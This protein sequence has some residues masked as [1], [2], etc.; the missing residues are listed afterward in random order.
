MLL[1]AKKTSLFLPRKPRNRSSF[2]ICFLFFMVSPIIFGQNTNTPVLKA[3]KQIEKKFDVKFSYNRRDLKP[4]SVTNDYLAET[5][6]ITL[7]RLADEGRLKFTQIKERYIAVQ[8]ETTPLFSVCGILIETE[9]SLPIA[10]AE[11]K[12]N[13]NT[14]RSDSGGNF[15]IV[16][17]SER[18]NLSIFV[19]GF[20]AR[21]I[22]ARELKA[23]G[24]CPFIY[25]SQTYTY[26]PEVILTNYITKGISKNISG[27]TIIQ[28]ENFDILPSLIEPD[29]LQIA[30]A[31]PGVDS[32]D[33]TAAN[34]NVRGGTSDEFLILWDDVRMY[35]SGHFFGLISAFNPNLTK[36]VTLYKNGTAARYGEG[37]SGVIAM[38]S[39]ST[40]PE[41]FQGGVGVNLTSA[42]AY[43]EIPAAE[44]FLI[45]VSG[46][47]SINTGIGNP[48]YNEFFS[49][50]FQN[51]VVTNLQNNNIEGERSTDEQ[52][53][54]FDVS[55][56]SL[57]KLT[58]N[59]QLTYHFLRI[60]NR[61]K[62][63]ER[64]ISENMGSLIDS[65]LEQQNATNAITY[66]R[67]WNSK[68]SSKILAATSTYQRNEFSNNVDEA[69]LS[70]N[71]NEV[72][73]K[74]VK[75][76]LHYKWSEQAN[77]EAGYQYTDTQIADSQRTSL[78]SN[79]QE[80]S[81]SLFSNAIFVGGAFRL[82]DGKT[83][84]T[85]GLRFTYYPSLSETFLEPRL[86]L[87]QKLN[88][89]LRVHISAETK[90]Q[91]V[92][93]RVNFR[94]NLL[95]VETKDWLLANEANNPI[96]ESQ[97][98]GIGGNFS[99]ANWALTADAYL[100]KVKG[101]N[102]ANLG[103]RNQ[104]QDVETIG[105]YDVMGFE[106]SVNRQ[107]TQWNVWVSYSAQKNTYRFE[108]LN[109][110]E[111]RNNLESPHSFTLAGSYDY[112]NFSFSLGNTL[113]SGLPYTRPNDEDPFISTP[114][115][116][117]INFNEPNSD[118]LPS[119]FRSDFSA[120]YT[121]PLDE[122]FTGKIN[123]AFLNIFNRNNAL[124]RYYVLDKNE[125]G[126]PT[127]RR[128]DQFSLGFTPNV[129]LQLLF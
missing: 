103:F 43:A 129:S 27:A 122:T 76:D 98:I 101:I 73:E 34:I 13:N 11:I 14:V 75:F 48:V 107:M 21:I 40:I 105:S 32:A 96:L 41:Q 64:I 126:A 51:T 120:S 67:N 5:L 104:F 102:S 24:S 124:G 31:L 69:I 20:L 58:A 22:T 35:L 59:D 118:R 45:T 52:F 36:N 47:T 56:K 97:Q 82:F 117:K 18:D 78:N 111:F 37:V 86:H 12:V 115:G 93:Q 25:I 61:L 119:Y 114:Q 128:V 62:F 89:A 2:I 65:E 55:V 123:I 16:G 1:K 84:I 90:H 72:V 87:S 79:L 38:E 121:L 29:V 83:H 39:N 92:Y 77:L 33:E 15:N 74:T 91:T 57:W 6:P 109:P 88:S 23:T 7:E 127:L 100:K 110:Q 99:K 60:D 3:L 68:F 28:N 53:N 112:K 95:G 9:S 71:R 10:D 4:I 46:R 42:N 30:Q 106:F 70:S 49:K 85:S 113:K 80:Q 44:N 125:T 108:D 66:T 17:L 81:N 8:L 94:N 54:F 19:N 26:L 116:S 63:S 50:V